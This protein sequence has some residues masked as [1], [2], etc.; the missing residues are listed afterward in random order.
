MTIEATPLKGHF[1]VAM[2][3]MTDPNFHKTV[4]L[5]CE[6][7][8]EGAMGVVVNRPLPFTMGQV[9][10]GQGIADRG[11]AEK[12]VNFGGPVQ[13]QVGFV[14]YQGKAFYETSM[15]VAGDLY[16][17]TSLEIL[18][19][20]AAGIGPANWLFALG[21]AGWG[22]EQLESEIARNDWL[23]VPLDPDLIFRTDPSER[24]THAVRS[25]GIDPALIST[26]TGSA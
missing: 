3:H 4:V 26:L 23:V 21:Y 1:L 2:P 25:L 14:L 17:G 12:H 5:M 15:Q 22:P 19:D 8:L 16:L 20:V 18:Q 11:H 7:N 6:H 13:P 10:E 24:W 9:Y